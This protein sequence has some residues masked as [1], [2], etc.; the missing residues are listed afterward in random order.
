MSDV[1]ADATV[2]VVDD[3]PDALRLLTDALEA[4]GMRVMVA[5]DGASALRSATRSA[6]DIVLLDA[7]MPGL[8][9]FSTCRRLKALTG[10]DAVPVLFMTGLSEPTDAIRGFEA[11]SAD[12]VVKPIV[13]EALLARMRVH[14]RNARQ[15]R[16]ARQALDA[17]DQFLVAASGTGE[18][19]WFTPQ[20]YRL[21]EAHLLEDNRALKL[22]ATLASWLR[23]RV[24]A[25]QGVDHRCLGES[26]LRIDFVRASA[27]DEILF[28]LSLRSAE[29]EATVL[30]ERFGLT[31]REAQVAGWLAKGKSNRDIAEILSL[32]PRTIDKHLELL[33]A[34]L[35]VENR[36]AAAALI[37]EAL[38]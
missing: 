11:G 24:E 37:I 6:P 3:A 5:L 36:T 35:N 23:S 25:R 22:P 4:A 33:F 2:L 8:D 34:K 12:Y 31:V 38:P 16:D 13:I 30:H 28:R 17:T 9:G 15:L 19:R 29:G 18:I 32:S 14:L 10:F 21:L 27:P 1:L 20:A 26:G 7:I